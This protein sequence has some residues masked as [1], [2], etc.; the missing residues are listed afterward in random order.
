M[1][2]ETRYKIQKPI[3]PLATPEHKIIIKKA[4]TLN[5]EGDLQ[6][7]SELIASLPV[8]VKYENNLPQSMIMGV[9]QPASISKDRI[10]RM[11]F[12]NGIYIH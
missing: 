1:N 6:Q 11:N 3:L 8:N 2:D 5:K 10:S 7:S 9:E 12:L 4:I